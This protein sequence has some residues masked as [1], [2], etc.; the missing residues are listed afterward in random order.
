MFLK[1]IFLSTG[2]KY[3]EKIVSTNKKAGANNS[4]ALS[5]TAKCAITAPDKTKK[6]P[7]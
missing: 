1:I 3:Q 2:L 7:A 5:P 6:K 4:I